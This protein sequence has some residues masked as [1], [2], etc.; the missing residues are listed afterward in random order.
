MRAMLGGLTGTLLALMLGLGLGSGP[1]SSPAAAQSKITIA[2]GGGACLCYLPTVLA[3]QLGEFDKAGALFRN[4]FF[5]REE[6]GTN[7]RQIWIRVR[8]LDAES[9]AAHGQCTEATAIAD[10]LKDPVEGLAFTWSPKGQ[11]AV[12]KSIMRRLRIT[13][14]AFAEDGYQDLLTHG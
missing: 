13:E 11:S 3:K 14:V 5:P 12:L 10:H 4:R 1:G 7:V 6:G 2:V 9:K 8:A